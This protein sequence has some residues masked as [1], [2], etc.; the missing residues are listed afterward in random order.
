MA[1]VGK[2]VYEQ[3]ALRWRK[4]VCLTVHNGLPVAGRI[5]RE[6]QFLEY[7]SKP[8]NSTFCTWYRRHWALA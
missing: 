6:A 8:S 5:P 7:Q 3:A 2:A 1:A 4:R